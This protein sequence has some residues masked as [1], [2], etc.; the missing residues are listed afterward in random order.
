MGGEIA[1]RVNNTK[2]CYVNITDVLPTR[3]QCLKELMEGHWGG[4]LSVKIRF[5]QCENGYIVLFYSIQ[6]LFMGQC[7]S[8]VNNIIEREN[9]KMS[10]F[11][12]FLLHLE[13][14]RNGSNNGHNRTQQGAIV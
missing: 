2:K 8:E 9:R 1:K 3:V 7:P 5:T 13:E 10:F 12:S 6:N 4:D 11:D 14:N